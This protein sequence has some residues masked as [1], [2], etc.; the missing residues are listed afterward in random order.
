[1]ERLEQD[2]LPTIFS[3]MFSWTL[4]MDTES[5]D[6]VQL[7]AGPKCLSGSVTHRDPLPIWLTRPLLSPVGPLSV[8]VGEQEMCCRELKWCESWR[9]MTEHTV[10]LSGAE[11][12]GQARWRGSESIRRNRTPAPRYVSSP[13]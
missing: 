4:Q 12:T 7:C 6:S 10:G 2:F 3:K 8:E 5:I 9:R 1:M 13:L 11:V